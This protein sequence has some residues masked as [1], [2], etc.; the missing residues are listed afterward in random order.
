[1]KAV[2][3]V[4]SPVTGEVTEINEELLDTP[5]LVNDDAYK[6][7]FIKVKDVISNGRTLT[8]DEYKA[9]VESEQE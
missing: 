7:W 5:E 4:Y 2:S 8:V 9:F 3:D 1:M 6:A